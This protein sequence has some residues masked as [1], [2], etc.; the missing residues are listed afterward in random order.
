MRDRRELL[1]LAA[2][3]LGHL[4]H[5]DLAFLKTS[6]SLASALIIALVRRVLQLVLLD[7]LPDLLRHLGARHRLV[8]DDRGQRGARASSPS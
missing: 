5:R 7:V 3:Q 2:D 4:E 8:A 6:F 1:Q